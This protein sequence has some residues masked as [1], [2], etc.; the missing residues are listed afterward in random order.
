ME[1]ANNLQKAVITEWL[2]G[3]QKDSSSEAKRKLRLRIAK[4]YDISAWTVQGI[5]KLMATEGLERQK[6][7]RTSGLGSRYE[8]TNYHELVKGLKER[9]RTL[10]RNFEYVLEGI[11]RIAQAR[12]SYE[13]HLQQLQTI[14]KRLKGRTVVDLGEFPRSLSR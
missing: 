4:K 2:E 13:I 9:V 5:I 10:E 8:P 1:W 3:I 7:K 12:Q 14:G 6:V 11:E